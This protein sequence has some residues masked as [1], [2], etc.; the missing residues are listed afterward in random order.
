[1]QEVLTKL[2][3]MDEKLDHVEAHLTALNG[4]VATSV[5]EIGKLQLSEADMRGTLK[6]SKAFGGVILMLLGT[7]SGLAMYIYKAD[8][9]NVK[10]D[11]DVVAMKADQVS[12]QTDLVAKELKNY[13]VETS[14][15]TL[16]II[17]LL[18]YIGNNQRI[19]KEELVD[20]TSA[21]LIKGVGVGG[22]PI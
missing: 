7:I 15:R 14:E 8:A 11:I 21:P 10:K 9:A 12:M 3:V 4:K 5:L 1:M 6:N 13:Q 17:R 2:A 18:Q 22:E 19:P 16:Q 20:F